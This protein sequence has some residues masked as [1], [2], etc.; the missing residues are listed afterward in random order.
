MSQKIKQKIK[1]GERRLVTENLKN[2]THY[3]IVLTQNSIIYKNTM[4]H[5]KRI[6]YIHI[7]IY[8][9]REREREREREITFF[10]REIENKMRKRSIK[11]NKYIYIYIV[12][13]QTPNYPSHDI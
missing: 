8:I 7:Y 4:I 2:Q 5:K 6:N 9:E 3:Q 10:E 13:S 12:I 11:I 1:E